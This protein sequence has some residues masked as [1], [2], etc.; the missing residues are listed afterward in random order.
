MRVLFFETQSQELVNCAGVGFIPHFPPQ[1]HVLKP[2]WFQALFEYLWYLW[3]SICV[4]TCLGVLSA[5]G[6]SMNANFLSSEEKA[7][8]YFNWP[9]ADIAST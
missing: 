2:P 1:I 6:D 9:A 8:P 5:C 3:Q 4:L 7:A